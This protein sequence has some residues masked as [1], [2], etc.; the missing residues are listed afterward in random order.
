MRYFIDSICRASGLESVQTGD[1]VKIK[2]NLALAHDGTWPKIQSL[3]ENIGYRKNDNLRFIVTVD[4][5]YPA[6]TI[7]DRII[8]TQMAVVLKERNCEIYNHGEGVLHQVIAENI[9]FTPGM[10]IV[11]ADGHVATA[12]AFGA[13]AFSESA[14]GLIPV[15]ET[16]A[17]SFQIPEVITFNLEG[18]IRGNTYA[19]DISL[20]IFEKYKEEIKGK[21]LALRGNFIDSLS[22][23]SR[24]TLCNLLPE[25]GVVTAFIPPNGSEYEGTLYTIDVNSIEP[26]IAV[27][28]SPTDVKSLLDVK[29]T[30]IT[31]A[32]VGGCSA[33]RMEDM[34]I[35]ANVLKDK[36]INKAVTLIVT[37]A[38]DKVANEMDEMGISK[39]LRTSGAV[40]MPP[41]CGPCP[42]KH[43]G[44]L[45][46]DDVAIT[47]TIRNSPGRMGDKEAKI[48]LASPYSVARAALSGYI[49]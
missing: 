5:A 17:Y 44:L 47:T 48:Y 11:G 13:I 46:P 42:G 33:G 7:E 19:R 30:K 32:I 2:V 14:E 39:I 25:G 18:K 45:S 1:E 4:H 6:P 20:Y 16:G 3:W 28:P 36:Q 37:P 49:E 38:S 31:M 12:G 35:V 40:I 23:D 10:I 22:S 29:G 8:Q 34:Q 26:K 27:P 24:M 9:D 43:F 15:L 41:G 21:A